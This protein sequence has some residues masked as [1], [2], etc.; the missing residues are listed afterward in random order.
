M[1]DDARF[2]D[3]Y[4]HAYGLERRRATGKKCLH[5]GAK[6]EPLMLAFQKAALGRSTKFRAPPRAESF[7]VAIDLRGATRGA[8]APAIAL[9]PAQ[10]QLARYGRQYQ[11]LRQ[12]FVTATGGRLPHIHFEYLG[13]TL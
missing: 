10:Q 9:T 7:L 13:A 11:L 8:S 12:H 6:R 2:L 5:A 1:I 3:I 4:S